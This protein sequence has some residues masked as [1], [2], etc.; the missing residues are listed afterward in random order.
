MDRAPA[1]SDDRLTQLTAL[2]GGS[3]AG[4]PMKLE[5]DASPE[6]R[7]VLADEQSAL[8]MLHPKSVLL[9]LRELGSPINAYIKVPPPLT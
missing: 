7:L 9:R 2:R 5:P 1:G 3:V 6:S 8:A 4:P